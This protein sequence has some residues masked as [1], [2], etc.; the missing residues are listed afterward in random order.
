M[1]AAMPLN[2][3]APQAAQPGAEGRAFLTFSLGGEVFAVAIETIREVI[4]FGG[5]TVVPLA[6]AAT[7][8]VINLRGAV[9]PVIDLAVRLG[10][11]VTA[12]DR[13]TC[14]VIL[15]LRQDDR[16]TLLGVLVD[17][18]REVL[19]IDAEA[20]EP[21]PAFGNRIPPDYLRAVGKVGGRF[22]L[23]LDVDHALSLAELAV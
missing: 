21:A 11:A 6:P 12:I 9:V 17:Q 3:L 15:E 2:T 8:G 20:L 10:H 1:S 23:I 4:Q 19:E 5:L 14:I 13:H 22:I 7:R 18:V 16:V